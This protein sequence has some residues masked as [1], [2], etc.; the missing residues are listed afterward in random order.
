MKKTTPKPITLDTLDD[1][2]LDKRLKEINELKDENSKLR[3]KLSHTESARE[4]WNKKFNALASKYNKLSSEKNDLEKKLL[5]YEHEPF[6][7]DDC[8][9]GIDILYWD[10]NEGSYELFACF[11]HNS[12]EE[13]LEE[14]CKDFLLTLKD[15]YL[16][17]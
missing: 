5:Y 10:E 8:D 17:E 2:L 9:D 3:L 1:S 7:M 16:V 15:T 14:F 6:I 4:E 11:I 12:L 13:D